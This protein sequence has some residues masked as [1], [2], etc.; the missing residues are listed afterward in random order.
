MGDVDMAEYSGESQRRAS[1]GGDRDPL[2]RLVCLAATDRD[3][4]DL[5]TLLESSGLSG[6]PASPPGSRSAILVGADAASSIL[7]GS[8]A[9]GGLD[10][11]DHPATPFAGPLVFDT[12]MVPASTAMFDGMLT[13]AP[14][15]ANPVP[16][17]AGTFASLA[18]EHDRRVLAG[19][20]RRETEVAEFV[21]RG[22]NVEE[23]AERLKREK[24][25]VISHRR[26]LL[27]KIG[28]RDALGIARFAY[29]VG[30]T[31]P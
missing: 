19:L 31:T 30:L 6:V 14:E 8:A 25:T 7:L 10:G 21:G 2:P 16:P 18:S 22:L 20:T 29:R 4:R 12:T 1:S 26:S 17:G 23:I 28:C 9:D 27:R 5:E 3:R 13:L 15:A 11:H 24:T